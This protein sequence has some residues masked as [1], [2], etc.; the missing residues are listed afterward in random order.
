MKVYH[1]A[2]LLQQVYQ[3]IYNIA[4][5]IT[6]MNRLSTLHNNL[7][8]KNSLFRPTRRTR[9]ANVIFILE[10][11]R[12]KTTY[13]RPRK[14]VSSTTIR[15]PK[16]HS[17]MRVGPPQLRSPIQTRAARIASTTRADETGEPANERGLVTSTRCTTGSVPS[18]LGTEFGHE[19][20]ACSN[21]PRVPGWPAMVCGDAATL[22]VG[23]HDRFS[24]AVHATVI[25]SMR[26][27]CAARRQPRIRSRK[28]TSS[29]VYY[30]LVPWVP[31]YSAG[32][33][34]RRDSAN[35]LP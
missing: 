4:C 17:H 3:Y 26:A 1:P 23:S 11:W 22:Q 10:T 27:R 18:D 16:Q 32:K 13:S 2:R 29:E 19:M 12:D 9:I 24:R 15:A 6:Y 5:A 14:L 33:D 7:A 8:S 20:G 31:R 35:S 21:P 28:M 34:T 30:I 25:S